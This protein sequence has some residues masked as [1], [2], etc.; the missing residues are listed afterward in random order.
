MQCTEH[1]ITLFNVG[2]VLLCVIYQLNC[3]VFIY[4]AWISQY[5][6]FGVIHCFAQTRQV[7][8]RITCGY[9]GTAVVRSFSGLAVQEEEEVEEEEGEGSMG[10]GKVRCT[11]EGGVIPSGYW[12]LRAW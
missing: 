9:G 12:E 8:K 4:V 10:K 3:T 5:L 6:A 7:S 1:F 11:D 2:N